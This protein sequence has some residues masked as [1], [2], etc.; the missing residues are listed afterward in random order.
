MHT[1]NPNNSVPEFNLLFSHKSHHV[2]WFGATSNL[3]GFDHRFFS[4]LRMKCTRH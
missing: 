4:L 1:Q 3:M 2:G